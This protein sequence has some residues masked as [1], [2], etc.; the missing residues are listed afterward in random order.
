MAWQEDNRLSERNLDLRRDHLLSLIRKAGDVA[1]G[2]FRHPDRL[3]IENKGVQDFVT[4]ADKAVETLL[5]EGI[6]ERFPGDG[7]IGE[8]GGTHGGCSS[9]GATWIID[10][11]DGTSNF[12]RGLPFW[13]ISVALLVGGDLVLGMILDPVGD[14]LFEAR[15]GQ[16]AFCNGQPIRVSRTTSPDRARINVGYS[17]R[18]ERDRFLDA[19]SR[20][21]DRHCEW[22][23][24][25]SAALGLAYVA[26]GR[27]D[28]SWAPHVN[29][30]DVAAGLCL[31]TQAGGV[32]SDFL[33]GDGLTRGNPL[34]SA[35]PGMAAFLSERLGV[36]LT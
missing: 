36:P 12:S 2:Y 18:G 34:L 11:I 21:I 8:E 19:I 5:V 32:V 25:G 30:W 7:F 1:L 13:C 27:L 3:C 4:A 33:G 22:N 31:V 17:F 20:L 29:V 35:T 6:R 14:E 9:T 26:C 16:G 15:K 24:L 28:G 23:R 10:P